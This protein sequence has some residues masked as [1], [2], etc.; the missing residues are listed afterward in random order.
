VS[1]RTVL[2]PYARLFT[3]PGSAAFS[4]AGWVARLPIPMLALGAVLLVAGETG[5]YALAGAVSGTLALSFSVAS[6]QWARAMDRRGQGAILRWAMAAYLVSGVAFVGVVV[7]G[8]PRW[9]WFVLAALTGASGP[10][11]GSLVRA[12]WAEALEDPMRR[13]T[14]FALEAVVDEV[15]FVVGP[16]LVTLLATLVA[17]PVGF[18]TGIVLGAVGGFWLGGQRATEPV[19]QPVDPAAPVRRW[20]ALNA[21]VLVVAGSYLAVGVVFGAMDVVV[22]GFTDAEGA[23]AFAGLALAVYAGGSLVA[24]LAYGVA[25]IPGTLTSRFLGTAVL[26]GLAA[27]LLWGVGSL[28]VLV[29][30][31]FVAGLTIAPVL[32]SGLSL[33]ESRVPRTALTEA[34]SWTTTGLTLGVTAGSALAGVAVDRW[35]A[36]SAF[37]VPAV[38]AAVAALLA[39]CGAPLLRRSEPEA[40]AFP[41][42]GIGRVDRPAAG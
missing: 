27:Q 13:Q 29:A 1:A 12:R 42:D 7:A 32:V 40:G 24:G 22:V 3:V 9:S 6:P 14:A 2:S 28:A 31:G 38:A 37:A 21:T 15:V 34:L 16:P 35:G 30:A 19:A 5:S 4:F 33:V 36:E 41:Q 39:L 17:P 11:I 20:A 26:F 25:H 10:N 18:L 23:P 8:G